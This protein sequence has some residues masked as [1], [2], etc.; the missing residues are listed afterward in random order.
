M[1][2]ESC[3]LTFRSNYA[4]EAGSLCSPNRLA[5]IPEVLI[6]NHVAAFDLRESEVRLV[7]EYWLGKVISWSKRCSRLINRDLKL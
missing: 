2:P 6:T 4:I 1:S 5:E 3:R 7:V